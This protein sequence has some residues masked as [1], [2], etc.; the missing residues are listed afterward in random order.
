[1]ADDGRRGRLFLGCFIGLVATALG[2]M[3]RGAACV[4]VPGLIRMT[5]I[6]TD[7]R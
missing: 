1:M 6:S 3:V 4:R 2:F 7:Q 5:R